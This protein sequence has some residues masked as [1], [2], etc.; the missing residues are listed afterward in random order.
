MHRADD[1]LCLGHHRRNDNELTEKR[2]LMTTAD[3]AD[4]A[5]CRCISRHD[6]QH[7]MG[8]VVSAVFVVPL[9]IGL[10]GIH[11]ACLL[12]AADPRVDI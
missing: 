11:S 5:S 8:L 4:L 7:V 12:S 2:M 9:L 6:L 10:H 1:K 3:L